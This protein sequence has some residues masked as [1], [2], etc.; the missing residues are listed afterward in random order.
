MSYVRKLGASALVVA[1]AFAVAFAVLVTSS[2]TQT[3]EAQTTPGATVKPGTTIQVRANGT[4]QNAVTIVRFEIQSS[5]TASG[6][7]VSGGGQLVNCNDGSACDTK[8]TD[9]DSDAATPNVDTGNGEVSVALKVANDSPD[10]FILVKVTDV[11]GSNAPVTYQAF[12]VSSAD[13]VT[14]LTAK[15]VPTAAP[16]DG[17][18]TSA[19]TVTAK[20]SKGEGVAAVDISV[21]T[22]GGT[23]SSVQQKTGTTCDSQSCTLTTRAD[24]QGTEADEAGTAIVT[25]TGADRAGDA[26]LTFTSGSLTA[27]AT[28]TLF[29]AASDITV[30]AEQGSAE[31]GGSTNIVVTVTDSA[32]NPVASKKFAQTD[33]RV[34]APTVA[35]QKVLAQVGYAK[36]VTGT[37][38]DLPSC[39]ED[40]ATAETDGGTNSK[41]QCVIKVFAGKKDVD[42]DGDPDATV[43]GSNPLAA[44]AVSAERGTHSIEISLDANTKATTEVNVSGAPATVMVNAP[45]SVEPLSQTKI[46]VTVQDDAGVNAGVTDVKVTK[47]DGG[48]IL[49]GLGTDRTNQTK[50]GVTS[51][52]LFAGGNPGEVTI[53]IDANPGTNQVREVITIMVGMPEP[54][55]VPEPEPAPSLDRTPAST[56]YT[57]VKFSGGSVAELEAV[58]AEVCGPS[59]SVYATNLGIYVGYHLGTLAIANQ[60]FNDLFADGIPDDEPLL[61]GGCS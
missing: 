9:D 10:G 3:A 12:N 32:G 20:N 45:D 56:G 40:L 49:E 53:V 30:E 11:L 41:G 6:S 14:S 18:S 1:A 36:D 24:D 2:S 59:A 39:G 48:G 21:I 23:M 57:L 19:I 8:L 26:V 60:A 50:D 47:V 13:V 15:A 4:A 46:T 22:T 5:S 44:Q 25:L 33:V 42:P 7:F 31:I 28:V 58:V 27:T 34:T 52:T 16:A 37:A 35:G 38:N 54:E 55:P 17:S 51:F 29:G 43:T 61:V